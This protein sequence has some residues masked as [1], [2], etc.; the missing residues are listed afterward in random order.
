MEAQLAAEV[1]GLDHGD[2]IEKETGRGATPS[3]KFSTDGSTETS[4]L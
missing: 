1:T 4:C 3:I 2:D